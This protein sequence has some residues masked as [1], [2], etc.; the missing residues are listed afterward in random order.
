MH[1]ALANARRGTSLEQ[2]SHSTYAVILFL[3]L[4]HV[5]SYTLNN[6]NS[7]RSLQVEPFRKMKIYRANLSFRSYIMICTEE[8]QYDISKMYHCHN[9]NTYD[10]EITQKQGKIK[11]NS[12][13]PTVNVVIK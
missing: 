13:I 3:L 12:P 4:V 1:S 11:E 10:R 6:I 2:T 8:K 5:P 9:P 7:D